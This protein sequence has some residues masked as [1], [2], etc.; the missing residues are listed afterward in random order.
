M[1]Y[2]CRL[3][4]SH[5]GPVHT[6]GLSRPLLA[7]RLS[8]GTDGSGGDGGHCGDGGGGGD[9]DQTNPHCCSVPSA[10]C[11]WTR[12]TLALSEMGKLS[13]RKTTP[14]RLVL[15]FVKS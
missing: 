4:R 2:L 13:V 12:P 1:Q 5:P 10:T 6:P 15:L 11:C 9:G 14:G 7:C 8:Q 3:W